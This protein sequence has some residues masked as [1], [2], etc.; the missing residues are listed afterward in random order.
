MRKEQIVQTIAD[1]GRLVTQEEL[2]CYGVIS[3]IVRE[4]IPGFN[5]LALHEKDELLFEV[6]P[7]AV[8]RA[9]KSYKPLDGGQSV[10]SWAKVYIRNATKDWL[11]ARGHKLIELTG[12]DFITG[13]ITGGARLQDERYAADS[14]DRLTHEELRE[15]FRALMDRISDR[16]GEIDPL[17]PVLLN[18]IGYATYEKGKRK[19]PTPVAELH[20][21]KG[22]QIK[23][24]IVAERLGERVRGGWTYQK[25]HAL[26]CRMEPLLLEIAADETD[27]AGFTF[28]DRI[29]Y[30]DGEPVEPAEHPTWD[31]FQ[32]PAKVVRVNEVVECPGCMHDTAGPICE[33]CELAL[34]K[35]WQSARAMAHTVRGAKKQAK[36][37]NSYE[38]K[39]HD[40]YNRTRDRATK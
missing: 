37:F 30:K 6:G 27:K 24:K 39:K 29:L 22:I 23:F 10:K 14:G 28:V 15:E 12:H 2:D 17:F 21:T 35:G 7:D 19:K 25:A 20:K 9:V 18:I 13:Q 3:S 4:V 26:W 1:T 31:R 16:L 5:K 8:R 38:G 33:N 32:V 40:Y 36:G 11:T 34:P